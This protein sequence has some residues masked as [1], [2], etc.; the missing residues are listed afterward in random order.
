MLRCE[1]FAFWPRVTEDRPANVCSARDGVPY[2]RRPLA[3]GG[4]PATD[5][6]SVIPSGDSCPE[7]VLSAEF[8]EPPARFVDSGNEGRLIPTLRDA[9]RTRDPYE[10]LARSAAAFFS[11]QNPTAGSYAAARRG[12]RQRPRRSRGDGP[13]GVLPPRASAPHALR[14]AP[15][16]GAG[17]TSTSAP[18]RTPRLSCSPRSGDCSRPGCPLPLR[19]HRRPAPSTPPWIARSPRPGRSEAPWPNAPRP[20]P[21]WGGLRC[22]VRTTCRTGRPMCRRHPSSSTRSP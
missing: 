20:V 15:V 9:A 6:R 12:A 8:V 21:L 1:A 14:R 19:L 13:Q 17:S 7:T 4:R 18:R 10:I 3:G 22:R 16:A 2:A 11:A 5:T